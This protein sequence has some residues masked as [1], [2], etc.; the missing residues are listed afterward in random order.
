MGEV[1]LSHEEA[2]VLLERGE[3]AAEARDWTVAAAC[4]E[5]FLTAFPDTEFSA[6]LWFNA[7][8]YHKFLRNWDKAY[9]LGKQAAARAGDAP[10]EP[11]YWNLGIAAT[12]VRDWATARRAWTK[13]GIT[14]TPGEG[15]IEDGFG[16]ACVRLDPEGDGEVVWV[17]RVC[18]TRARVLSVPFTD[19]RFGEIVVHDGAPT[20][21]RRVGEQT[22][23]VFDELALWQ[24]SETATWR[25]QVTAP[26]EA[27]MRALSDAFIER[28]LAMEPVDSITFHCKC[29]SEGSIEN[30]RAVLDGARDVLLA[31]P[32]EDSAKAV[33]DAWA[34]DGTGR[35]WHAIHAKAD[36][37]A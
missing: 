4:Y 32:D 11:A 26:D 34:G 10:G 2:V 36:G 20:G 9:E 16:V 33:L 35:A 22:Y 3:T 19:R 31:A 7:A 18:P 21:E 17:D 12:M 27:D 23:P 24:A 14:L 25:A 1:R 37:G 5:Q 15:E 8:L 13:F 6:E 29:C 28:D 30:G